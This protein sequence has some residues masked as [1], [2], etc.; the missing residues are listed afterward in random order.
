MRKKYK[1]SV[2]KILKEAKAEVARLKRQG[3]TRADF[4]KALG[5]MLGI[6]ER[7]DKP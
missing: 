4:A 7:K 6:S 3:W 2:I 5:E 1:P